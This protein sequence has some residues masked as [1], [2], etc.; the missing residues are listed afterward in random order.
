MQQEITRELVQSW[1]PR[2]QADSNKGS[3]GS[4]LTAAGSLAYRGAAAL[5]AEGALRGGAGLVYLAS[6]EPVVQMVLARTPECC[7]CGCR[8]AAGG[9]IHPQ[10]AAALRSWFAEK[11][12]VLLAGPG[13]G[14]G[15]GEVCRALLGKNPPWAGAVLDADALNALAAGR[16]RDPLPENTILTPHPGEA[17]RLLGCTVADVQADREQAVL[18]LAETYH[19]VAVLKGSGTLIAAP[20]G[21]LLHNAAGNAGLARGGSGDILAGLT[22]GLL[23]AGLKQNRTPAQMAACAVW[24]HGTAADRCARRRS[25]TAML[26]TD[27]FADLGEILAEMELYGAASL[28]PSPFIGCIIGLYLH[29]AGK[30]PLLCRAKKAKNASCLSFWRFSPARRTKNIPSACRSWWKNCR[31]MASWPSA[32]AST[33]T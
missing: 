19:C 12:A 32:R 26:P 17:A 18:R 4:V 30:E 1:L 31:S 23:A 14:E 20:G 11:H 22:A 15:A 29:I 3:Y 9:G 5:C 13:L 8:T 7:A 25:M 24:L 16:L 2:R 21:E 10:D 28:L 6:V 27:I 33:M